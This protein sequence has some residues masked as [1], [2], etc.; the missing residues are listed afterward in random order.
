MCSAVFEDVAVGFAWDV[1][2]DARVAVQYVLVPLAQSFFEGVVL[3]FDVGVVGFV[4]GAVD[5]TV[6]Y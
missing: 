5:A 6:V 3:G 1:A 2:G 4:V